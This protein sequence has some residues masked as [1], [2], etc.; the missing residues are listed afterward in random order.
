MV[1][2]SRIIATVLTTVV[3][4]V[5][6]GRLVAQSGAGRPVWKTLLQAP[7]PE[8]SEPFISVNG[9]SLPLASPVPAPVGA[10]HTHTGPVFA[11]IAQG[12]IE[13]QVEPDPP[14]IYKPGGFFY[15]PRGHV[16][17][18]LRNVSTAEHATLIIFQAGRTAVPAPLLKVLQSEPVKLLRHQFQAPPLST[19]N[20]AYQF[21][22]PLLSTANQ[23]L[24]LLR[25]ALPAGARS[26]A[27]AHSVRLVYVLEGKIATSGGSAQPRTPR[28]YDVGDLFFEPA[29][30]AGI[31]FRNASGSE[32]ARILVYQVSENIRQ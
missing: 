12:E 17:R 11:Y 30:R 1:Q 23:E 8:D 2:R 3:A 22:A 32:P 26:D 13:N 28:T 20:Q 18:I 24:S 6:A 25:L 21:Q 19:A 14:A 10:G 9:L 16:H 15:E 7:L 31:T 29:S 4:A 5:P 27:P